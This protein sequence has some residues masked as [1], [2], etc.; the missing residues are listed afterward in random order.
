MFRKAFAS[1][2]WRDGAPSQP[3]D[4]DAVVHAL[5]DAILGAS[6]LG[7][8]GR[9]FPSHDPRWKD[10]SGCEFLTIVAEKLRDEG[11]SIASA[12]V[13]AIAE[14]PRLSGHLGDMTEAMS[15]ALKGKGFKFVGPVI[16]YAWMQAV[17]MV[18]DHARDCFRR[19]E[20]ARL[21]RGKRHGT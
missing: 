1:P 17:G 6:G 20:V 10:T 19:A 15:K 7:D 2:R 14:E 18:N 3:P 8:M 11:W 4:G 13:I 21:S 12:H 9:H 16:V 5:V